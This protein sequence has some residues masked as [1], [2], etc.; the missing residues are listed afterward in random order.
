MIGKVQEGKAYGG[1]NLWIWKDNHEFGRKISREE[2]WSGAPMGLCSMCVHPGVCTCVCI[3]MYH[4][5]TH[6]CA[7]TTDVPENVSMGRVFMQIRILEVWESCRGQEPV[8]GTT[9]QLRLRKPQRV[10]CIPVAPSLQTLRRANPCRAPPQQVV[11]FSA[12]HPVLTCDRCPGLGVSGPLT[13]LTLTLL[14]SKLGLRST[15]L[16]SR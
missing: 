6:M 9:A 7:H 11:R 15:C 2:C 4:M 10:M 1:A 13:P 5:C 8:L 16:W 14:I 3:C 12:P